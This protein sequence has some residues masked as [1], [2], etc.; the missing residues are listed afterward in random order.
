MSEF[1]S[2]SS[3]TEQTPAGA[4]SG[5]R[6]DHGGEE[7]LRVNADDMDFNPA[8]YRYLYQGKP[9]TGEMYEYGTDGTVTSVKAIS[10]FVEGLRHGI[11]RVFYPDGTLRSEAR[12]EYNRPVGLERTWHHNG[13]LEEEISYTE[14]G[15]WIAT[16]R[17]DE[18]GELVFTD[19]A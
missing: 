19:S 3:G 4:P 6:G 8:T 13:Q 18:D 7:P 16:R 11:T 2:E 9:F 12:Y 14:E 10:E 5:T 17:W 15:T 1:A